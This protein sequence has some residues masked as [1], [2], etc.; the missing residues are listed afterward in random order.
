MSYNL[1]MEK[2][3]N[4]LTVSLALKLIDSPDNLPPTLGLESLI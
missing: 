4:I 3:N 1:I 2:N